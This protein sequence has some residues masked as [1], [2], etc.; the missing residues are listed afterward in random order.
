MRKENQ[1]VAKIVIESVYCKACG[2]CIAACKK[3]VI[4]YGADTN[5]MGYHAVTAAKPEECVG[6]SL[7]A[8]VCPE[9]AIEVYR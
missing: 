9:A 4:A 5:Q 1:Q 8:V 6:C 2:L 7:C 3:G